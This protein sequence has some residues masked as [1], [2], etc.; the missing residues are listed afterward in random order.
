[1]SKEETSR[2]RALK[3]HADTVLSPL[4][5][6]ADSPQYEFKAHPEHPQMITGHWPEDGS[7]YTIVVPPTTP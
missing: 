6:Y 4:T 7:A 1:M 3:N 5:F 2:I